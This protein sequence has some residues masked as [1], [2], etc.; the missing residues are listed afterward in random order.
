MISHLKAHLAA[1]AVALMV[2]LYPGM[3]YAQVATAPKT[4]AVETQM[5]HISVQ[6]VGKGAPV[7]LIPGLSSPRAVWDGVV[8]TLARSHRVY[9]VQVNGF[10]GDD[11]RANLSPG[12]LDGIVGDLHTLIAQ[13]KIA[14]P[15]I[16]GHSMGGLVALMLAKAHPEDVGKLMIVDSLPYIGEIFA[17]GAT[18]AALEPQ[19]K[20]MRA[21][22]AAAYGKPANPATNAALAARMALKPTSRATVADWAAKADARVSA[23]AM[24]EDLTTDLRPDMA[25]IAA[26]ITL[27]YPWNAAAPTKPAA[28][29][30]Y[31]K[32]YAAAPR[33]TFVDI[34]DA[35]H[36]VMLDQPAAFQAALDAIL[37][38]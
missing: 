17:P 12:I 6:T 28:D 36:F 23:Q 26:P 13:S 1:T 31:R 27:V 15:A 21:G 20:A 38:R 5:P 10:G 9:V 29:A 11:P 34:G 32:A 3:S 7:I 14:K 19:A 18:V 35:A 33:V 25:S 2:V 8:P 4:D 37:Q 24:Y 22:M 16:V 30:L